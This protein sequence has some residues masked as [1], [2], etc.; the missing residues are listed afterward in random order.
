MPLMADAEGAVFVT[1]GI[2]VT[3]LH[4]G[5]LKRMITSFE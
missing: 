1:G 2:R 4:A 3:G 5:S